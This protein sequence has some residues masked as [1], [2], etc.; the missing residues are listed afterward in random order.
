MARQ[1]H[2]T[3]FTGPI[4][5]QEYTR[6]NVSLLSEGEEL[7]AWLYLPKGSSGKPPVVIMAHGGCFMRN[8]MVACVQ[9]GHCQRLHNRQF[10]HARSLPC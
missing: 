4:D 9:Q 10:Q 3:E 2:Q 1:A 7:D 8:A 6:S 5:C